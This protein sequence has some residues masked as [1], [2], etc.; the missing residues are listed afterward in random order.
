MHTDRSAASHLQAGPGL[1][2]AALGPIL[3]AAILVPFREAMNS[4]N[5]AL[6]LVLVVVAAAI[7]G[8]RGAG[9]LAAVVS[10]LSFDFFFTRPYLSLR[11]NSTDDL[12]TALLLL[13]IGLLVGQ[14]VVWGQRNRTAVGEVRGELDRIRRVSD[15]VATGAI[16]VALVDAVAEEL[17]NLLHLRSCTWEPVGVESGRPELV[18]IAH[19]GSMPGA[20]LVH[21][22]RNF[23][24][25]EKGAAL[26]VNWG[27]RR[28]GRFIL[29]PDPNV[30]VSME[31]RAA[32]VVITELF[33]AAR[34]RSEATPT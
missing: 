21:T 23:V 26:N 1:V 27:D 33:A 30:G 17:S 13:A 29:E 7:A 22:G 8:G 3:V 31:Q 9:V 18:V 25:P 24:L 2:V 14:V 6:V 5:V 32:A 15:A 4:A 19:N 20:R 11:I 10:T 16:D 28:L 34:V 12:E